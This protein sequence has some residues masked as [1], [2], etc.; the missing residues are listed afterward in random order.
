M[1]CLLDTPTVLA[2]IKGIMDCAQSIQDDIKLNNSHYY[3]L[4]FKQ[5]YKTILIS[6]C[7]SNFNAFLYVLD[8]NNTVLG[9][10]HRYDLE[11]D[12]SNCD[13]IHA[14]KLFTEL[15]FV[16]PEVYII[17]INNFK[18]PKEIG[19]IES[20]DSDGYYDLRISC[21]PTDSEEL[22]GQLPLS[23]FS[24]SDVFP[25]SKCQD[26]AHISWCAFDSH[27]SSS[28]VQVDLGSQ[29]IIYSV[30]IVNPESFIKSFGNEWVISYNLEH[31]LDGEIFESYTSNPIINENIKTN[32]Q[33]NY[34]LNVPIMTRFLRFIPLE[35]HNAKTMRILAY[36][37][38]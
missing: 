12:A 15:V 23:S 31:S 10:D 26:P 16:S 29:S 6:L 2:P 3:Q 22:L 17:E 28:Y 7:I 37:K 8:K 4:N 21:I 36:G 1:H 38:S 9:N 25:H 19:E 5:E 30:E 35:F 24:W 18:D 33:F 14:D 34:I 20:Y 11:S 13:T 32:K 27:D